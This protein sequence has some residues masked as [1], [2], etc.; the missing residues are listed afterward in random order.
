ML[1]LINKVFS[2]N[3]SIM[4]ME[5]VFNFSIYMVLGILL[6]RL[7]YKKGSFWRSALFSLTVLAFAQIPFYVSLI[8]Y[9][10]ILPENLWET[11]AII[12]QLLLLF[13]NPLWIFMCILS[14]KVILKIPLD[15]LFSVSLMIF[16]YCQLFL[17]LSDYSEY[18]AKWLS[19]YLTLPATYVLVH[20]AMILLSIVGCVLISWYIRRNLY[21]LKAFFESSSE[22]K[23]RER[24][25][26]FVVITAFWL[27]LSLLRVFVLTSV[28]GIVHYLYPTMIF[29]VITI[30]VFV[31]KLK[32]KSAAISSMVTLNHQMR[33]DID[34]FKK[35]RH[36]F[37]NL[38]QAYQG[39]IE[40]Q[41]Y[42]SLSAYH[43]ELFD[44]C[45]AA[46]DKLRLHNELSAR[47]AVY[48][49]FMAMYSFAQRT[50]VEVRAKKL[51]A[52]TLVKIPDFDFCRLL[53][54]LLTNAIE[55]AA[56]SD[57]KSVA[58][59]IE[60]LSPGYARAV[61]SNSVQALVDISR[62]FQKGFSTKENHLGYGLTEVNRIM[63]KYYGCTIRPSCDDLTFNMFLT[64]PLSKEN[65][66][67]A[68]GNK[69]ASHE[70]P[71]KNTAKD[72]S[73][74]ISEPDCL[75]A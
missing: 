36:D 54:N 55:H 33:E 5:V 46:D 25:M 22:N 56:A 38:L 2:G 8:T 60:Q 41:D 57:K 3:E 32:M 11:A 65:P 29:A 27:P 34:D 52:F 58:I 62:I 66:D 19:P 50:G 42:E 47:P 69:S 45:I 15:N 70:E 61:I 21:K 26:H 18:L 6:C 10:Y 59:Y 37:N 44:S 64:L 67:S 63:A 20:F 39:F 35:V 1:D 49:E 68:A 30:I 12:I 53:G 28:P 71:S 16:C 7:N 72:P 74:K 51:S 31:F 73:P 75:K 17:L 14:A 43:K 23:R 40:T 9:Q 13:R 24:T 4:I 48:G